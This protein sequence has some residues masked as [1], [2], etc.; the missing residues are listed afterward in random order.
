LQERTGKDIWQGLFQL[1]LIESKKPLS[2]SAMDAALTKELGPG[3]KV[4]GQ[5]APVKHVLSHQVIH[6]RF[7]SVEATG[8][9][10]VPKD[11]IKVPKGKVDG[12][13]LPRLIERYLTP[14]AAK[15][16]R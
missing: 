9:A 1:P 4:S 14:S 15:G 3:W 13:A 6:A 2:A 12:Y 5:H 7:W 10:K 11:W 8:K 16:E